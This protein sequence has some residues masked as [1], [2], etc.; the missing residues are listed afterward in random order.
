MTIEQTIEIPANGWVHLDTPPEWAGVS[1][2]VVITALF[3][4]GDEVSPAGMSFPS[5]REFNEGL[6][7]RSEH[8]PRHHAGDAD[9]Q[10]RTERYRAAIENC[11]GL[12]K[13]M[14]CTATSDDFLE[15]RRKDNELENR[16]DALHEEERRLAKKL[17]PLSE[18][19]A[20]AKSRAARQKLQELCKDS[21][22]TV[23]SFLTMK[24]ADRVLEAA[25]DERL[26][27]RGKS[28]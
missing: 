10:E 19:E 9:S 21:K 15:Q 17:L 5:F 4:A 24:H 11:C 27:A 2:H 13:R 28:L 26:S 25:I 22:L 16:L 14:G 20:K 12:A 8:I 3:P 6:G 1:G 7:T 18:D 23:E